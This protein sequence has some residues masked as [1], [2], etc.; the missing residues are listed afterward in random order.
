MRYNDIF[1]VPPQ[2]KN[3]ETEEVKNRWQFSFWW[4]LVRFMSGNGES[5]KIRVANATVGILLC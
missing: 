3:R 1:D 2:T 5:N 4:Y